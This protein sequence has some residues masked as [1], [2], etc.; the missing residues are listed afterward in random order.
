LVYNLQEGQNVIGGL[1][2]FARVT[3][4]A[5]HGNRE[6]CARVVGWVF[7]LLCLSIE[8]VRERCATSSRFL[9]NMRTTEV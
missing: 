2:R 6:E 4:A 9:A 8:V 1:V 3:V 5:L 7:S